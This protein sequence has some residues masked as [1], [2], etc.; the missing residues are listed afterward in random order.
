MLEYFSIAPGVRHFYFADQYI[1][2]DDLYNISCEII[3]RSLAIRFHVMGRPTADY[4]PHILETAYRAGCCW[5][6]W[7][8]E[9]GSADLLKICGKGTNPADIAEVLK[10]SSNCGISNLAMMIF[11][12]PGSDR[13]K[14]QETLDFATDVSPYVDA[15]TSSLFQLFEGTPFYRNINSSGII[16]GDNEIIFTAEE[17]HVRTIRRDYS[18]SV[19]PGGD[20][21][22]GI[23]EI[24]Q[25]EQWRLWV[26]GGKTFSETLNSEHYLLFCAHERDSRESSP[27]TPPNHP[28]T[29][30]PL[31][32]K[33]G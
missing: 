2:A 20:K 13:R 9:T 27:D 21:I 7:G 16:A 8:V 19:E 12:L 28:G 33:T 5:I 22:P 3:N 1:S 14:F 32:D 18:F 10:N 11:G 6:S 23:N 29:P 15:F 26:R 31:L 17:R 25:W 30:E 24:S 4:T